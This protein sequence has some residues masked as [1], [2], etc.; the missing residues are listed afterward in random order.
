MRLVIWYPLGCVM[1]VLDTV[2]VVGVVVMIRWRTSEQQ[3]LAQGPGRPTT[4]SRSQL[5]R[6]TIHLRPLWWPPTP[7][8][9]HHSLCKSAAEEDHHVRLYIQV[10][11]K[12]TVIKKKE[13]L[14]PA[15]PWQWPSQSSRLISP[16]GFWYQCCY[17]RLRWPGWYYQ[18][19]LPFVLNNLEGRILLLPVC[20]IDYRR[21]TQRR[22]HDPLPILLTHSH[23]CRR[24]LLYL[25]THCCYSFCVWYLLGNMIKCKIIF[26]SGNS[27]M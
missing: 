22:W 10:V 1:A 17:Q 4:P 3:P 14:V 19:F 9:T 25:H 13:G 23:T 11:F 5:L 12:F 8:H 15:T 21:S 27:G 20:I 26:F 24:I 7:H 16:M 18:C 2:V 6:T